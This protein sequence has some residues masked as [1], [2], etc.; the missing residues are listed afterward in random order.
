M[1]PMTTAEYF[2]ASDSGSASWSHYA[3]AIKYYTHFTSP[4]RRYADVTV[5]RLLEE[6]LRLEALGQSVHGDVADLNR[7]DTPHVHP[8]LVVSG[9][10]KHQQHSDAQTGAER[11]NKLRKLKMIADNCNER[12]RAAKAAQDRSDEV[13]FGIYLAKL[14][15]PMVASAVVISVGEKSFTVLVPDFGLRE[16]IFVD[17]I[18][19]VTSEYDNENRQ[20]ILFRDRGA[21]GGGK[22]KSSAGNDELVRVISVMRLVKVSITQRTKPPIAID[23]KLVLDDD[24]D[25]ISSVNG[26]SLPSDFQLEFS[27]LK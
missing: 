15:Q 25:S 14:N 22:A 5:H 18:S 21:Y 1:Q 3:L 4:I 24:S 7:E 26:D 16:R 17:K 6:G 9:G 10:P 8:D 12:K 2:V 27:K 13:F 11:R 23:I 19:G 20:I